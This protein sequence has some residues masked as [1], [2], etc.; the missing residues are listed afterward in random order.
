MSKPNE[1]P[2]SVKK[3]TSQKGE[4]IAEYDIISLLPEP[5]FFPFPLPLT[6]SLETALYP[7]SSLVSHSITKDM[8]SHPN[9]LTFIVSPR[10]LCY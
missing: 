2:Q 8:Y 4:L 6:F 10:D 1:N 3:Q 5:A 9:R 7:F